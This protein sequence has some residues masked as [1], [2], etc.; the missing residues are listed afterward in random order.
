MTFPPTQRTPDEASIVDYTPELDLAEHDTIVVRGMP[1]SVYHG[2]DRASQSR[3]KDWAVSIA[4][5][6][7]AIGPGP[8]TAIE[9]GKAIHTLMLDGPELFEATYAIGGPIN[10]KTNAPY[11]RGTKKFDEWI[12]EQGDKPFL[13]TTEYESVKRM[14]EAIESDG[15]L[16]SIVTMPGTE[17]ELSLFWCETIN[18]ERIRCKARLDWWNPD[19]GVID[20]KSTDE[21]AYGDF[22]KSVANRGWFGQ[23][24]WYPRGAVMTGLSRKTPDWGWVAVQSREP[25][26]VA[27]YRPDEWM[28]DNGR[29]LMLRGLENIARYRKGGHRR[30]PTKRFEQVKLPSF[31]WQE[32]KDIIRGKE[33]FL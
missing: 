26:K 32:E 28:I 7:A 17:R 31:A 11:N 21:T 15:F 10:P 22:C 5:G 13:T 20:L 25:Y 30:E 19:I 29:A 33:V 9:K 14:A 1:E 18:G 3:L 27:A 6:L 4:D 23:T 24:F 2:I 16:H 12:E 8:T